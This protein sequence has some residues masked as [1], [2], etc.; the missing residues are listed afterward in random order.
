[1]TEPTDEQ[2]NKSAASKLF[3]ADGLTRAIDL[4]NADI[5][6]GTR[7]LLLKSGIS[8]VVFSND[9]KFQENYKIYY[10]ESGCT[11]PN[12]QI[13]IEYNRVMFKYLTH[14]FGKKWLKTVRKDVLG[15]K[16]YK[17]NISNLNK[18]NY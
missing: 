16:G 13:A 1:M 15:L 17:Q 7:F 11:G 5:L 9:A 3:L 4:A 14:A 8:P 6:S 2:V 10:H 18:A 12:E